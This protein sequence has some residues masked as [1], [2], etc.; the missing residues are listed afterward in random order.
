[1]ERRLVSSGLPE[2]IYRCHQRWRATEQI[3]YL[4]CFVDLGFSRASSAGPVGDV[5]HTICMGR[6]GIHNHGHQDFVLGRD[7]PILQ[8]ALALHQV[9]LRELCV[10]LL[11]SLEPR[12]D[13]GLSHSYLLRKHEVWGIETI[14]FTGAGQAS[15]VQARYSGCSRL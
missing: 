10:A 4:N 14:L 5:G 12:W 9:R 13:G 2:G 1:M 11:E 6:D 3:R 15:E 8:D 7:S